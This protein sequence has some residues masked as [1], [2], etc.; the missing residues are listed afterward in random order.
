MQ[1]KRNRG[2]FRAIKVSVVIPALNSERT[3]SACISSLLG[4]SLVPAEIILSDSGSNDRTVEIAR[5]MGAKV[6][7]PRRKRSRSAARN[8]GWRAARCHVV[9]FCDADT[10]FSREWLGLA[11]GALGSFDAVAD[12]R[13]VHEPETF[14]LR[15]LQANYDL[16]YANYT[17][18]CAW[19]MKRGVLGATGGFN[20][21]L[22][23]AE[24]RD[25]GKRMLASGFT[26]GFEPS[27]VQFHAGKPRNFLQG[28]SRSF[29]HSAGRVAYFRAYP[30]EFPA[31]KF[32]LFAAIPL[33]GIASLF[34]STAFFVF[35]ATA[36]AAFAAA[37][38]NHA[39]RRNGISVLGFRSAHYIAGLAAL[40][41]ADGFAFVFGTI[42]GALRAGDKL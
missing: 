18:F 15:L 35:A 9:A 33:A 21:S 3:I 37:I 19:V 11:A 27:A 28:I 31:A 16:N 10:V 13:A 26:I 12:R 36:I 22:N 32:A 17:P 42:Y 25:L 8:A 24:E 29:L 41:F 23:V 6:V 39:I 38:L 2:P 1:D 20:E 14:Y 30:S 7:F 34:W 4:Q 5:R 40:S